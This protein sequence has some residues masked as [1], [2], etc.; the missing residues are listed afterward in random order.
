MVCIN[1]VQ[2]LQTTAVPYFAHLLLGPCYVHVS[3]ILAF[4]A[5]PHTT[6]PGEHIS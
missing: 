4:A 1:V 5:T 2:A 3:L 6:K